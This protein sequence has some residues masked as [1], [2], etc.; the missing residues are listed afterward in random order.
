MLIDVWVSR[1]KGSQWIEAWKGEPALSEDDGCYWC[2]AG[3]GGRM[4]LIL[5]E[6]LG[7]G[8]AEGQ[9]RHVVGEVGDA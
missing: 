9:K 1:D 4:S 5:A 2:D 7:Y 3:Y 6:R 8:V